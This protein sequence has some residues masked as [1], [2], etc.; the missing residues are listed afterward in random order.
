MLLQLIGSVE[1]RLASF[2]LKQFQVQ[3]SALMVL[4]VT[5]GDEPLIAE[6]ALERLV[7]GMGSGV[8]NQKAFV[9]ESLVTVRVCTL[10]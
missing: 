4:L 8:Q 9:L 7:P 6:L 10:N 3:M 5:F 1:L 2:A